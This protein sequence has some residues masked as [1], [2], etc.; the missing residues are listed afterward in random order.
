M[1]IYRGGFDGLSP[2]SCV[3]A[4]AAA[5]A[6]DLASAL[7]LP[8]TSGNYASTPDS[9]AVSIT[10]DIDIRI[11]LSMADWTPAA[12]KVL[13][14]KGTS[15]QLAVLSSGFSGMLYFMSNAGTNEAISSVATGVTD[16]TT[17]WVRAARVSATGTV[18]FYTS[19]DY[20]PSAETGTWTQL[21]TS[22]ASGAAA[23]PDGSQSVTLGAAV[24]GT[25]AVSGDI[26][27]AEIRSG[28]DGTVVAK[29]D[30]AT[31]EIAG[32]RD[33]NTVVAST[34][35]TWTVAGSAWDWV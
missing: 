8:G 25:S 16:G 29:F 6:A 34:G 23:I 31:V 22:Q 3:S 10:G 24:D 14:A 9:A 18:T 1:P 35:E 30:P 26:Q 15:Y 11:K 2:R 13:L 19:S 5:V 17:K 28:I 27:Y 12:S 32:T 21:G 33:P 20:D 7:S 4:G